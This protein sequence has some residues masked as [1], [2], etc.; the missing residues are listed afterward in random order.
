MAAPPK[1]EGLL[2]KAYG[3]AV[4]RHFLPDADSQEP[5]SL[6]PGTPPHEDNRT[7]ISRWF[8][9]AD[10]HSA[11]QATDYLKRLLAAEQ[12]TKGGRSES[13]GPTQ[14]RLQEF[15][16]A[17][18][19]GDEFLLE[20]NPFF[21]LA[22]LFFRLNLSAT[23]RLFEHYQA[24]LITNPPEKVPFSR[25]FRDIW[26]RGDLVRPLWGKITET[27]SK[28]FSAGKPLLT[29]LLFAISTATTV[30]AANTLLQMPA[31]AGFAGGLFQGAEAE[32]ARYLVS[33]ACGLLLSSAVLDWKRQL[34]QASV[35]SGQIRRG[36][37]TAFL[38]SP[39]WMVLA[40]LLLVL[41]VKA[42]YDSL[43]PLLL[44]KA[45][46][47]RQVTSLEQQIQ[48]IV[49][50]PSTIADPPHSL[51]GLYSALSD[52]REIALERFARI[53]KNELIGQGS[54]RDPRKGPRYWAKYFI[55]NGGY[56][57]GERTVATAFKPVAFANSMDRIL[58]ESGI[59]LHSPLHEKLALLIDPLRPQLAQ[60]IDTIRNHL[61]RMTAV[62]HLDS[63]SLESLR[64][65][66]TVEPYQVKAHLEAIS[67]ALDAAEKQFQNSA[68]DF[69]E[70]VD[71][72]LNT[73]SQIDRK[74]AALFKEGLF[75]EGLVLPT[76]QGVSQLALLDT[77]TA[78]GGTMPQLL[79]LFA[80]EHGQW[81]AVLLLGLVLLLAILIDLGDLA[82]Y[83]RRTVA[84]AQR[85]KSLF[86]PLMGY[87]EK[88]ETAFFHQCTL[89]FRQ[90]D[91][92]QVI[93][94]FPCPNDRGIRNAFHKQLET[95]RPS[96]KHPADRK[97]A[98]RFWIWVVTSV[99]IMRTVSMMGYN[100]RVAAIDTLLRQRSSHFPA[101]W[102][103]LMPGL[104]MG[105]GLGNQT[106]G[107]M[108]QKAREIQ[109]TYQLNFTRELRSVIQDHAQNAAE[110]AAEE[111]G[112]MEE[113]QRLASAIAR[114]GEEPLKSQPANDSGY[115]TLNDATPPPGPVSRFRQR[116]HRTWLLLFHAAFLPPLPHFPHTRRDW[117]RKAAAYEMH[118][119]EY[120]E[121]L[122]Q[123]IPH[124]K[125][126]LFD[127]LPTL[128]KEVLSPLARI[129]NHFPERFKQAG[130]A[131]PERFQEPF[132]ALG[133]DSLELWRLSQNASESALL[134]T[135][136]PRPAPENR[137]VIQDDGEQRTVFE[138]RIANLLHQAQEA[139]RQAVQLENNLTAEM[140][141][142]AANVKQAQSMTVTVLKEIEVRRFELQRLRPPPRDLLAILRENETILTR[143]PREAASIGANLIQVMASAPLY[144]E[145]NYRLLRALQSE[146][147]AQFERV[148]FLLKA[149]ETPP[150]IDRR[151][152]KAAAEGGSTE[153]R[154][155]AGAS[156]RKLER[157]NYKTHAAID[158]GNNLTV[159]GNTQDV[160][161]NG[162]R[163]TLFSP[164]IGLEAE[165]K[166]TLRLLNTP[167]GRNAFP[168]EV[169]RRQ[170]V[171]ITLKLLSGQVRFEMLIKDSILEEL[172]MP[173]TV[174]PGVGAMVTP[175]D[176][177]SP[178]PSKAAPSAL[179][180]SSPLPSSPL[181]PAPLPPAPLP[182]APLP[183]APLPMIRGEL[184][185]LAIEIQTAC[186]QTGQTLLNINMRQLALRAMRPTPKELLQLLKD[187]KMVLSSAP[188]E[189]ESILANLETILTSPSSHV[190]KVRM[191]KALQ[192]ESQ[193]L[194]G[195]IRSIHD[196]LHTLP[197]ATAG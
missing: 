95:I 66:F 69:N 60:T 147:Q 80:A 168:C 181:P 45:D 91:M 114:M 161:L 106:F 141:R 14:V 12:N 120:I 32:T 24:D 155:S 96:V 115:A 140:D 195:N 134:S 31:V 85:E 62:S 81:R 126:M 127:K 4:A 1:K 125:E 5:A 43:A 132:N 177:P 144:N 153:P 137:L 21:D 167:G 39:R 143:T 171:A 67:Q 110:T 157:Q 139:K 175:H 98:T 124:L 41:S 70:V 46:L 52:A 79:R 184:A 74:A 92:K 25:S 17:L 128:E 116:C 188:V 112:E 151:A 30:R 86:S 162:V 50:A 101:L 145:A 189:S 37:H 71:A 36:V 160:S 33:L 19:S 16:R 56:E 48:R 49:G 57:Q 23:G 179:A 68:D 190:D 104:K 100:N 75:L 99:G 8:S 38:R 42:N 89:M 192:S 2:F 103:N 133:K 11:R 172:N 182:P 73:L 119:M 178:P 93:V 166:I 54:S 118:S 159:E 146:S 82:L 34:F 109:V 64:Q 20:A 131:D 196:T 174:I 194:L 187:N 59:D 142:F 191:I 138:D 83:F 47:A 44:R 117:L 65:F 130:I 26:S 84:Q 169:V 7:H 61:D 149:L 129:R 55:V 102:E 51:H 186:E 154:M 87:L 13:M 113:Q 77:G 152:A 183:P 58:V 123:C 148:S 107:V 158:Y 94:G 111:Q 97:F 9:Q 173:P 29:L 53:P 136:I 122:Q 6:F 197:S 135:D 10:V 28:L 78:Q 35:H 156:R 150:H 105:K 72:H 15:H 22:K 164:P 185:T 18:Q 40:G 176:A 108:F 193:S 88:W 165:T 170:G 121:T 63:Y 27:V 90:P 3:A 180:P 163:M 76:I